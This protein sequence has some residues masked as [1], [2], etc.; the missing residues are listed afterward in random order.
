MFIP[1]ETCLYPSMQS[2]LQNAQRKGIADQNTPKQI[3][4]DEYIS[5]RML[6]IQSNGRVFV[7]QDAKGSLHFAG[8]AG[9]KDYPLSTLVIESDQVIGGYPGMFYQADMPVMLCELHFSVELEDG[10]VLTSASGD[11]LSWYADHFLPVTTTQARGLTL[12]SCS[13]AP[14]LESGVASAIPGLPLPG[15][16]GAVHALTVRNTTNEPVHAV[17][18]LN[19]N[20]SFCTTYQYGLQ[21]MSSNVKRPMLSEWDHNII[22]L[23]RPDV[24]ALVQAQGFSEAGDPYLPSLVKKVFITPGSEETFTCYLALGS[25]YSDLHGSL[26][27]L[28]RHSMLE[29]INVAASFWHYRIGRLTTRDADPICQQSL[30]FAVRSVLDNF[31]CYLFNEEGR[32]I[33]HNQGAPS[34]NSG[35]FWGIDAEPTALSLLYTLPELA[36]PVLRYVSERNKPAYTL[37]PDHST[38]IMMA[39]WI[40]AVH[41]VSLT[42]DMDLLRTDET[43]RGRMMSDI[44]LLLSLRNPQG[45]V[46]SRYSS[47]GHVF[48]RYDFGT[49]C[50]AYYL[51]SQ[52]GDLL[53][54]LGESALAEKCR[55]AATQIQENVLEHMVA[56]GPFG[57]Q[58]TGG[59]NMGEHE[60]F[61]LQDG[62]PYYDGEDSSSCMAPL[63]GIVPFTDQ[64]WQNYHRF[65]QSIFCTNYD[66]EMRALRW[67]AWGTALD[68]TALISTIGGATTREQMKDAL[69][70]MF[71]VGVDATGSLFWWPRARNYVRGLTR[72]SQGQGAW[73]YQHTK[74]WLGINLDWKTN[75]LT[76][77]PQGLYND[78]TW[79]NAHIGRRRFDID[80]MQN[81][82]SLSLDVVNLTNEPCTVRLIGRD[83]GAIF[84]NGEMAQGELP[85]LGNVRLHLSTKP[86]IERLEIDVQTVEN[87][88]Y[89]KN[90]PAIATYLYK[91]NHVF[92]FEPSI[93]I[94]PYVILSGKKPLKNV[95]LSVKVPFSF[96]IQVKTPG[97]INTIDEMN[98][99]AQ[100]DI[101]NLEPNARIA[102]PF[103]LAL[104]ARYQNSEAWMSQAPFA[105]LKNENTPYEMMIKGTENA[106][107]GSIEAT[108]SWEEA[109]VIRNTF[110]TFPI[111]VMPDQ[112]FCEACE[113]IWGGRML[114]TVN[115][116]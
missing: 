90:S 58:F 61:Y 30:D 92:D 25:D 60:P 115:R 39:P 82:E 86:A 91:M 80:F 73:V 109:G 31:N 33:I 26:S 48:R 29:W 46:P 23:W 108:L 17:V 71:Q 69:L 62:F 57:D 35:R 100:I 21:S 56:P 104:P 12:T 106:A 20:Q 116:L 3:S 13:I 59:T 49:N 75:T 32:L 72:C 89:A 10:D 43:L 88:V 55:Q 42:G 66:P 99:C 77:Q 50:K 40:I 4:Q 38:P 81:R 15:P 79:K 114:S 28:Y 53:E 22:S 36:G 65:A 41:Y 101:G 14:L 54:A 37:Y 52:I 74:Q 47:D 34:H 84:S 68:G 87:Q 110:C 44:V 96:M 16:G 51:F 95:R 9:K 2:L 113:S 19:F 85:P 5:D 6:Y 24:C 97:L 45:L 103:Y 70:N 7:G 64:R 8:T 105:L 112:A 67:F 27:V 111:R 93:I 107:L 18:R 102:Q 83:A 63:Y 98:R 1:Q 78:Y 76:I 94:L 11:S